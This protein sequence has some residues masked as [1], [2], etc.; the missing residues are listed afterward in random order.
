MSSLLPETEPLTSAAVKPDSKPVCVFDASVHRQNRRRREQLLRPTP[1][2]L[3]V[4]DVLATVAATTISTVLN[5]HISLNYAKPGVVGHLQIMLPLV[6]IVVA[7]SHAL[8]LHDFRRLANLKRLVKSSLLLAG[9]SMLMLMGWTYLFHY[10]LVG[11][12]LGL[13]IMGLLFAF[14]LLTRMFWCRV[15]ANSQIIRCVVGDERSLFELNYFIKEHD[16]HSHVELPIVFDLNSGE[17]LVQFVDHHAVDELIVDP[18]FD[19]V[20]DRA[21]LDLSMKGIRITQLPDY[22][23]SQLGIVA[24][25]YIGAQWFCYSLE[26]TH[27]FYAGFKRTI[28]VIGAA[29]GLVLAAPLL[30]IAAALIRLEGDGPIF[31]SQTRVGKFNRPF[32]IYKLRSMRTDAESQGAQ[33]ARVADP[34]V[35]WV[36]RILR[37]TRIDEIPQ[38]WNVIKGDMSIVGP[39]PERP[40]FVRELEEDV[41]FYLQRHLS[42]PGITGWAQINFPY[43]SSREDAERKLMYDLYYLRYASLSLDLHIGLR[44]VAAIMQGAR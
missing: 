40:E 4:L 39:R 10:Q 18:R 13:C 28:D 6:V 29:I 34:R 12:R 36:G 1:M 9:I 15:V 22:L 5:P 38:F 19:C 7:A 33:W 26:T 43:G 3:V 37:R 42:P 24:I 8:G 16:T 31:Y 25:K 2:M 44:T 27:P 17:S 35:T 20:S 32:K 21:L 30:A 41:P 11:R 14:T 23:S